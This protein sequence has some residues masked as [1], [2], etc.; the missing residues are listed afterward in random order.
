[1]TEFTAPLKIGGVNAETGNPQTVTTGYVKAVK[2]LSL[3]V[4]NTRQIVTLPANASLTNLYAF[5]TS[6]PE[7]DVSA[8]NV[9]FGSSGDATHYGII[10]VSALG[11]LRAAS[12]SAAGEF[13]AATTIVAVISAVSTTTFTA[14]GVRAFIEYAVTE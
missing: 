6:A 9:S 12:V 2:V 3:G 13:D 7:A 10:A 14:G 4:S 8:F 5:T 1:M 11:Q